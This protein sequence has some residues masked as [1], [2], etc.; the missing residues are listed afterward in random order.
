MRRYLDVPD[1][2]ELRTAL[3]AIEADCKITSENEADM[4][5]TY[6]RF[7]G[8]RIFRKE[9]DRTIKIGVLRPIMHYHGWKESSSLA[10]IKSCYE[11]F[12]AE[13][14]PDLTEEELEALRAEREGSVDVPE[15]VTEA[16]K[17]WSAGGQSSGES[18]SDI[19]F[20]KGHASD[21][22]EEYKPEEKESPSGGG[23][24][25]TNDRRRSH[26]D[27]RTPISAKK[28]GKKRVSKGEEGGVE[29]VRGE[30][31]SLSKQVGAL[32]SALARMESH[33]DE[34]GGPTCSS[35]CGEEKGWGEEEGA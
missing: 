6:L 3:S 14:F 13:Y 16:I 24:S 35:S 1:F 5:A 34:V 33:V 4:I 28:K 9:H 8:E 7:L 17:A 2:V 23:D 11:F 20:N 15:G 12:G 27:P 18:G 19:P 31:S 21:V 22:D 32:T 26:R 30:V 25:D 29:E 10:T